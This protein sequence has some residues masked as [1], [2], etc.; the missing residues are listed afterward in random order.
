MIVYVEPSHRILNQICIKFKKK[1]LHHLT[2][3]VTKYPRFTQR[4]LIQIPTAWLPCQLFCTLKFHKLR[5]SIIYFFCRNQF[6]RFLSIT[7]RISINNFSLQS[8]V[9]NINYLRIGLLDVESELLLPSLFKIYNVLFDFRM[10][11]IIQFIFFP[12]VL[13]RSTTERSRC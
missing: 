10:E 12:N 8:N 4:S 11:Y 1:I 3:V 7:T 13:N 9:V 5:V 6:D 2:V